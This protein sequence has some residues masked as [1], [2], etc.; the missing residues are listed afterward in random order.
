MPINQPVTPKELF[1]QIQI[2]HYGILIGILLALGI[3]IVLTRI[4]EPVAVDKKDLYTAFIIIC[5]LMVIASPFAFMIYN[6][7]LSAIRQ[8]NAALVDKLKAYRS[9]LIVYLAIFEGMAFAAMI[10]Y[11]VSGNTVSL[12]LACAIGINILL[13]H[14]RKSKI[15]NELQLNSSEQLELN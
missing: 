11:V 4:V 10:M 5:L 6:K 2:L 1:R 15:F 9:A 3:S 13:K 8:S 7:K 12:G 14:P